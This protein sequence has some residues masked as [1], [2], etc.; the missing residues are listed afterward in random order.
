MNSVCIAVS[1]C[2]GLESLHVNDKVNNHN[3]GEEQGI[4][5]WVAVN[6][7]LGNLGREPQGTIGIVELGGDSLQVF[8]F[9]ILQFNSRT[10]ESKRVYHLSFFH[11]YTIV[12]HIGRTSTELEAEKC[13]F[14]FTHISKDDAL[15]F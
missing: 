11:K 14:Y 13:I 12:G 10:H 8:S 15:L 5:S 1:Y 7:A 4:S 9:T 2:K 6:F 3:T